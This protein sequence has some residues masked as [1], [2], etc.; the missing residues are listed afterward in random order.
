VSRRL[1]LIALVVILLVGGGLRVAEAA[2]PHLAYESPDERSYGKLAKSLQRDGEYGD[3]R[4]EPLHW[5]PGAPFVFALGD[6]LTPTPDSARRSDIPAAYWLQALFATAL[7]G[8]VYA[9][10]ALLA[11]PVAGLLAAGALALYPPL[12]Y[13]TGE[14][15][16]EPLGALLLALATLAALHG[17]RRGSLWP[18]PVAGVLYGLTILTRTDLMFMLPIAALLVAGVEWR[19]GGLRT[20]LAAGTALAVAGGLTILPWSIHASNRADELVPVTTG[21]GSAL[22]VGTYLPGGGTTVGLKYALA[23][24]LRARHPQY[25]DIKTYKIPAFAA[26]NHVARRHPG[27]EREAALQREARINLVRY[28]LGRPVAFTRMVLTKVQRLWLFYYRGGGRH[29]IL[30]GLRAF[31]VGLVLL[32]AVGL[33]AGLARRRDAGLALLAITVLYGTLLHGI[34]VSQARYNLPLLPILVAGGAAGA[35]LALRRRRASTPAPTAEENAAAP[36]LAGAGATR[37]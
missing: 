34:F 13:T 3:D 29:Y 36:V 27:M 5:P 18:F 8:V 37:S 2:S 23:D 25:R 32:A 21:G 30:G 20:G 26:L 12:I 7:L 10:A 16:S 28:G 19:R 9:I 11:G 4:G 33:A 31:H 15:M 14:L 35:V 1:P 17:L 6:A 24:E 22:F